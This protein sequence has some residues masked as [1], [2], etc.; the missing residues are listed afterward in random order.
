M[1]LAKWLTVVFSTV[2]CLA[3]S[4]HPNRASATL[5]QVPCRVFASEQVKCVT[6]LSE[7]VVDGQWIALVRHFNGTNGGPDELLVITVGVG[8]NGLLTILLPAIKP[9][10]GG[11]R[12]GSSFRNGKLFVSNATYLPGEAHCCFTHMTF[13]RFG[14]HSR[15]LMVERE[16]TVLTTASNSEVD[17]AL[18]NGAHFF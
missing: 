13:R 8:G 18:E 3:A 9:D 16:A 11:D 5:K 1:K 12:M 7:G 15:R 2:A 17:A 14:F 4:Q 6:V 10:G